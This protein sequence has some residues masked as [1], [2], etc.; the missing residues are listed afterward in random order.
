[1]SEL[2]LDTRDEEFLAEAFA[3]PEQ[4]TFEVNGYIIID[5]FAEPPAPWRCD[6]LERAVRLG[7]IYDRNA[8][9]LA[10]IEHVV[11]AEIARLKAWA[12]ELVAPISTEQAR[13]TGH[14]EY[15]QRTVHGQGGKQSTK[16]P[17]G[18]KLQLRKAGPTIEHDDAL[19]LPWVLSLPEE[20]RKPLL[21]TP[22]VR[23][24]EVKKLVEITG[25]TAIDPTTGEVVPGITVTPPA[26]P[27][28]FTISDKKEAL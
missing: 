22:E 23:W 16:L 25:E 9:R 24:G 17:S 7:R 14:L 3:E 2:T 20:R 27:L 5:P 13:I 15:Y 10:E 1:M 11:A 12:D 28:A 26:L 6:T 8:T 4:P 19:I 21:T 18:A